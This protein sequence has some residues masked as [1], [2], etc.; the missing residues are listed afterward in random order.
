[1]L[2]LTLIQPWA[3]AIVEMGKD[4]ENRPWA[5]S[6]KQLKPGQRFAIHAGAKLD[7]KDAWDLQSQLPPYSV[8]ID[9][10]PRRALLGTVELVGFL[11]YDGIY[12]RAL[13]EDAERSRCGLSEWQIQHVMDSRWRAAGTPC[14]WLLR[15][16]RLLPQPIPCQGSLGLWRVPVEHVAALEALHG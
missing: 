12:P 16:P 6:P 7:R 1:M 14:A 15:N 13:F 10:M 11:S 3:T 9:A 5:P 8:D 2:A 4:V